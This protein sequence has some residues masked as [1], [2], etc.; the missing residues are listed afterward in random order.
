MALNAKAVLV[1]AALAAY[2]ATWEDFTDGLVAS[3][4]RQ[5]YMVFADKWPGVTSGTNLNAK[6]PDVGAADR[7][8][9]SRIIVPITVDTASD[10]NIFWALQGININRVPLTFRITNAAGEIAY[11]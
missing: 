7:V 11:S 9:D 1:N 4:R 3:D 5:Y 6:F 10:S 2:E 8:N